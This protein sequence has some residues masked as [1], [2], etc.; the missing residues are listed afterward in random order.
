MEVS[1]RLGIHGREPVTIARFPDLTFTVG[2]GFADE[3]KEVSVEGLVQPG[4]GLGGLVGIQEGVP[5]FARGG[6]DVCDLRRK[7]DLPV[8]QKTE[9]DGPASE[10]EER[11]R[12]AGIGTGGGHL[13]QP[14]EEVPELLY[15]WVLSS[16]ANPTRP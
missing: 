16:R 2:Y 14:P 15:A 12:E 8:H 7:N 1:E 4:G 10:R 13:E 5:Q 9:E 11:Q 6:A 3:R